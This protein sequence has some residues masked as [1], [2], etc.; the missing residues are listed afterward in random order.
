MLYN[1]P[2]TSMWEWGISYPQFMAS[3]KMMKRMQKGG[4]FHTTRNQWWRC[5]S[6]EDTRNR[7]CKLEVIYPQELFPIP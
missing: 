6:T 3:S 5:V 1:Y 7:G 4:P 2:I